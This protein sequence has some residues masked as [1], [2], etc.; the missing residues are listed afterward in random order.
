M[1]WLGWL[2]FGLMATG[3]LTAVMVVAQMLGLTRLDL[4]L[5]LGTMASDDVDR[6]RV[7]GSAI[8]IGV[9]QVF[10]LGYTA[11]FAALDQASWWLGAV[12][13][14][15]HG[16]VALTVL[17]PTLPGLNGRIA[18][19]RA[20]PSSTAVLEPPGLL[21]MNYGVQTP[22]VTML[23]HVCYGILLGLVLTP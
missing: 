20:G 16:A 1:D 3:L 19:N 8:H 7:A 21:A 9:G 12:F 2:V 17:V 18:S 6:A 10:A 23:A 13:G 22:V 14:L 4:P 5:L 11:A 15:L